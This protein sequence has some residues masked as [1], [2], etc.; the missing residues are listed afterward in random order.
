MHRSTVVDFEHVE[1]LA[2]EANDTWRLHVRG[3]TLSRRYA[4]KVREL[5][6]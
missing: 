5:L 1:R 4:V 6:A 2:R 3:L